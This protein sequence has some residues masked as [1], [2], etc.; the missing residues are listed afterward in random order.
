MN[1]LSKKYIL[2][3]FSF[4]QDDDLSPDNIQI[5]ITVKN[6]N[7][8]SLPPITGSKRVKHIDGCHSTRI[9]KSVINRFNSTNNISIISDSSHNYYAKVIKMLG[10]KM[11][12]AI[13]VSYDDINDTNPNHKLFM[14]TVK[15]VL[16]GNMSKKGKHSKNY[17][18]NIKIAPN[19]IVQITL[20]DYCT[21]P[22]AHVDVIK[23]ISDSDIN[24]LVTK[25]VIMLNNNTYSDDD[26]IF[27]N[28]V[29]DL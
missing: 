15:G 4:E 14:K 7:C 5:E 3:Q 12:E 10:S 24:I 13:I 11:I 27:S 26:I 25:K 16:C 23:K 18:N 29:S 22:D 17:S 28:S 2:E 9:T 21:N 20:R 1:S 8:L 6:D 19:S